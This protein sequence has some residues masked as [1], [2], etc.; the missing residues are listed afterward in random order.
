MKK[1]NISKMP[2]K[3]NFP[4]A[5]PVR[6]VGEWIS[7][8]APS[9]PPSFKEEVWRFKKFN[10]TITPADATPVPMTLG[11]LRESFPWLSGNSAYIMSVKVYGPQSGA[12]TTPNEI[13]LRCYNIISPA[14]P[15]L[16]VQLSD[17]GTVVRP[18]KLGA[19]Q[20]QPVPQQ[21]AYNNDEVVFADVTGLPDIPL[22]IQITFGYQ[23]PNDQEEFVW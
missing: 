15:T 19:H 13:R 3:K 2:V 7:T 21:I 9:D 17:K 20:P 11:K 12:S 23:V 10:V 4:K 14:S 6:P 22:Y 16:S 5:G 18:A 8:R 1:Q